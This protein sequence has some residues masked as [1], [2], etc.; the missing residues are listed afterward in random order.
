MSRSVFERVYSEAP[1]K[2]NVKE[3]TYEQF[4][5]ILDSDDPVF[6]LDVRSSESYA[7]GH[8]SSAVSVP[9]NTINEQCVTEML[10]SDS[11]VVVYCG[12]FNCQASTEAANK[13]QAL[14]MVNVLDFKGGAEEWKKKGRELKQQ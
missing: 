4:L 13:L 5:E 3:I 2:N 1:V 11:M 9:V 6:L 7:A 14:G 12:G 10:H 8:I